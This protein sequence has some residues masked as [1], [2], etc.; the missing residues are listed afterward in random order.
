MYQRSKKIAEPEINIYCT[1][2]NYWANI[3]RVIA[4]CI[5]KISVKID[6]I[7]YVQILSKLNMFIHISK[8]E[9]FCNHIPNFN[10]TEYV[11]TELLAFNYSKWPPVI[12]TILLIL[13]NSL[14]F[15]YMAKN[16]K[17]TEND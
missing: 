12:I 10:T 4:L 1:F 3:Y 14:I 13:L 8:K 9:I 17:S 5:I 16:Y 11:L 15:P 2:L 6:I 7:D